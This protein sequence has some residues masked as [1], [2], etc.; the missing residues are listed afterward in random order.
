M[1]F[2][3]KKVKKMLKVVDYIINFLF[4]LIILADMFVQEKLYQLRFKHPFQGAQHVPQLP[5]ATLYGFR[6]RGCMNCV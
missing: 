6:Q 2:P 5:T 4:F 3:L 1:N